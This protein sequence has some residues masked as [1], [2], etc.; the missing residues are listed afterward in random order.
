MALPVVSLVVQVVAVGR[1]ELTNLPVKLT[2]GVRR[3]WTLGLW[4]EKGTILK[5]EVEI[6]Y[7]CTEPLVVSFL[8]PEMEEGTLQ[9]HLGLVGLTVSEIFGGKGASQTS[10]FFLKY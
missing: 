4:E 8:D 5:D 10:S 1:T 6:K 9:T 7:V 3:T 2:R